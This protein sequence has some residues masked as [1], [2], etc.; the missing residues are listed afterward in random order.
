MLLSQAGVV[1]KQIA[2]MQ[3]FPEKRHA[4][5]LETIEA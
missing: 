4:V 5:C 3:I 1:N 2:R